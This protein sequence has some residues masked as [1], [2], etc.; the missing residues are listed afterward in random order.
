VTQPAY[1][2]AERGGVVWTYVGP[3]SRPPGLPDLEWAL[4]PE[5]QRFVS[6]F[7]QDCNYL[8]A[9]EGGVDPAHIS[10]LHG[11]LDARDDAMRRALDQAAVG[12]GFT[13][14]LERAPHI[15]VADTE[16]GLLIGA[17]AG[18]QRGLWRHPARREPRQ[19]LPRRLGGPAD[20]EVL[21]SAG[22]GRPGQ[23]PHREPGRLRS[24]ARATGPGGPGHHP[25][26]QAAAGGG[27]RPSCAR[28]ATA[29]ARSRHLRRPA[30]LH[31]PAEGRPVGG[32]GE[33]AADGVSVRR[34]RRPLGV[35]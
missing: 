11:I 1:P 17:R 33:E 24:L 32:G 34:V 9:L 22:P 27:H 19:R 20:A 12:F 2:C 14:Q 31:A 4:V 18:D 16:T 35:S 13:S 10:F 28:D 8:Q 25:R 21:R 6:K 3:A 29:G 5:A 15:E 26:A 23:G 30:G 7:W